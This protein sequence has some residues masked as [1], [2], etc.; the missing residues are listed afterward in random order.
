MRSGAR[1]K[2]ETGEDL[3]TIT[4]GLIIS[5]PARTA[6]LHVEDFFA[7]TLAAAQRYGIAHELLDTAANCSGAFRNFRCAM[8]RSAISNPAPVFCA[9]SAASPRN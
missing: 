9:P 8:A 1:S 6:K 3:L 4:G 2:R 5:S 7:N